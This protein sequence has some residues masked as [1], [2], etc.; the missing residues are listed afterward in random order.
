MLE[1]VRAA[2]DLVIDTSE[3]NVHQL[4]ERIDH[5]FDTRQRVT[6]ADRRR[7]LRVQAR[8]PARRRH[9]D[10][11]ALPAQPALGGRSA[12]ADRARS[13]GPRL[14]A[15]DGGRA[16]RSSTGSTSC[17]RPPAAVPGRG[18]ELPD[19]RV[20]LHRRPSPLGRRRRGTRR[21]PAPAWRR[22]PDA[23]TATSPAEPPDPRLR[24]ILG[25]PSHPNPHANGRG[26]GGLARL[27]CRR[28]Y[29]R[30]R[31]STF[32]PPHARRHPV[33]TIRVGINGFGRIGRNFFRA[34]KRAAPTSTSWR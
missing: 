31:T 17:W 2:A 8:P 28:N 16:R 6:A 1:P 24:R 14:R 15:G 21:P 5:A 27:R 34:A 3:L 33:M 10:G 26:I 13:E 11:R 20:R 23:R 30:W 29:S 9:R 32:T 4:K 25:D 12:P 18:K 19:G 7:E 22:R